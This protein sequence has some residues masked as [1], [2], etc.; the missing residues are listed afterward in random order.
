MKKFIISIVLIFI[1]LSGVCLGIGLGYDYKKIDTVYINEV[2]N[3]LNNNDMPQK[4]V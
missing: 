3:C 1:V 4:I 2:V